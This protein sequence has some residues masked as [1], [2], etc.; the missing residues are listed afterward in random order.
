MLVADAVGVRIDGRW[1]LRDVSLTLNAGEVTVVLGPNGAGKST[2]LAALSGERSPSDGSVSLARR[3]L[4]T[5]SPLA[6][7]RRRAVLPQSSSLQFPFTVEE[8]VALGRNPFHGT[9]DALADRSIVW[10]AMAEADIA[11]LGGRL[12]PTLSGGERQRVHLARCL[13]QLG[14]PVDDQGP[15]ALLLDEPTAGLDPAHQHRLMASARRFARGGGLVLAI[16]H[17]LN[18]AAQYADRL[19][20]LHDGGLVFDGAPGG[21]LTPALLRRVFQIDTRV[22]P[23]PVNGCPLVIQVAAPEPHRADGGPL[24]QP[25]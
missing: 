21:G 25:A 17:D 15:K 23:H 5:W 24:R 1:I 8:V 9:A 12:V 13:A 7:A 4:A 10:A 19:V 18:L 11:G 3:P 6:L 22:V 14:G 2:L 16:V 20:M